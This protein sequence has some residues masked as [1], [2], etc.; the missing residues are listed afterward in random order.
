MQ[1]DTRP[2]KRTLSEIH[3]KKKVWENNKKIA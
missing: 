2:R 1:A 3:D